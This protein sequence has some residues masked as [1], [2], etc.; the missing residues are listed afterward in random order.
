[1]NWDSLRNCDDTV[2]S[3]LAEGNFRGALEALVHGYQ[4]V[5]VGFCTNV[6]GDEAQA[7]EVAQ[8]VFL[9]AYK[10]MPRFR[11][12]SSVRTWLFAI[13]RK[14]CLQTRRNYGRRSRIGRD[15]QSFIAEGAHRDRMPEPGE[16]PEAL[17]RLI[18]H[19]LRQLPDAERALLTMRY[20]TGLSV[21]DMAHILGISTASVRR[22]LA[23]ALGRL[24]E[25]IDS[26]A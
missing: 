1:M 15:K 7:E 4:H 23:Q 5:V 2:Q 20:D 3:E 19:S 9:A 6:L 10:A 17:L 13:A 16:E 21:A 8:E 14:Q 18:Q 11:Q 22:R 24:R 25:V 26:D 12:Q